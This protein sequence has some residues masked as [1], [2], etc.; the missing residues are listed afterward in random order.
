MGYGKQE[1]IVQAMVSNVEGQAKMASGTSQAS[2][3]PWVIY[4]VPCSGTINDEE[5]EFVVK[6]NDKATADAV[7]NGIRFSG[8]FSEYKGTKE[9]FAKKGSLGGGIPRSNPS[10]PPR[11]QSAGGSSAG[12]S[13]TLEQYDARFSHAIEIVVTIMTR[14]GMK[15]DADSVSRLASTWMIG[16]GQSGI[17]VPINNS[18]NGKAEEPAKSKMNKP[19]KSRLMIPVNACLAENDIVVEDIADDR[20]IE[21]WN[22]AEGDEVLFLNMVAKETA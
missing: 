21:L 7:A 5:C 3:K 1:V 13:E 4:S 20:L 9:V 6:T 16:A 2:G 22:N 8:N 17:R 15:A 18:I 19:M 11:N 14:M 12:T 10:Y